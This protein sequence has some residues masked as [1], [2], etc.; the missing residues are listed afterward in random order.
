MRVTSA[1][2]SAPAAG[3]PLDRTVALH[4]KAE[5]LEVAFLSEMLAYTGIDDQTEG[6]NGGTGEDQFG[7]FMREEQAKL[8]VRH[9]GIGLAESLFHALS[10][11]DNGNR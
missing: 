1:P 7:S 6:F 4:K 8:M 5:A 11:A 10:R 9:G 2:D 3:K